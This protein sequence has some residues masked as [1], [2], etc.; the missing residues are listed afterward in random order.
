LELSTKIVRIIYKENYTKLEIIKKGANMD[1]RWLL[2]IL[3]SL[4]VLAFIWRDMSGMGDMPWTKCKESL[5]TQVIKGEC[6]LRFE[7]DSLVS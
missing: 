4:F 5:F 7:A 1:L 6:T 3:M 2:V